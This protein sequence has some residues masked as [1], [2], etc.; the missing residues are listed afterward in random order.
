MARV[1]KSIEIG[2]PVHT[3]YNQWTQ[4]EEFPHFM[5]G[6]KEVR[7]LDDKRLHW[8]ADIG[9]KVKEWDA[10]I[11]EQ[12][13]DQRI[14]WRS[15]SGSQNFG[16]VSFHPVDANRTRVSLLMDY[17]P[18]GM[19]EKAGDAMGVVSGKVQGDLER[20]KD[21]IES[22]GRESGAWR[23]EIHGGQE[24]TPGSTGSNPP[25]G[26]STRSGGSP[27]GG[28]TMQQRKDQGTPKNKD[29]NTPGSSGSRSG[30]IRTDPEDMDD[31][32]NAGTPKGRR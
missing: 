2:V 23:G 4:F 28:S 16:Q 6:V 3:A 10:E 11:Q 27:M 19:M 31:D 9:G 8:K 5:D 30:S 7:Q 15:I 14:A 22:R 17:E 29:K 25:P 32:L 24:R 1:E 13:P 21:F 18:E 20:F 12:T 26:G